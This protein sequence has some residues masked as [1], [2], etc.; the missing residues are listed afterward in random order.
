M[1]RQGG[2]SHITNHQQIKTLLA[3]ELAWRQNNESWMHTC[4]QNKQAAVV[5]KSTIPMISQKVA[6]LYLIRLGL[7][8]V[9]LVVQQARKVEISAL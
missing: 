4:C 9:V 6:G 2:T 7:C 1:S 8:G 5:C 3:M